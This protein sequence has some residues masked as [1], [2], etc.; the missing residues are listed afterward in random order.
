MKQEKKEKET[1]QIPEL[2][3]QQ[4]PAGEPTPE[5]PAKDWEK[6][7]LTNRAQKEH[8]KS[9][10]QKLEKELEILK[11]QLEDKNSNLSDNDLIKIN[12]DYDLMDEKEKAEFREKVETKKRLLALEAKEKMRQDYSSLPEN[13]KKKVE[14]R[15]GFEIFRDFACLP[16]NVGQKNVLNLARA[17]VFDEEEEEVP[18]EI[19]LE[20]RPGLEQPSSEPANVPF[21]DKMEM[22]AQQVR[23]LRVRNPKKYTELIK[24]K[25]LV[26]RD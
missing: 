14:E 7:A 17:F 25:K 15:G 3:P 22:T 26:I 5:N 12:P 1:P 2:E 4:N 6:E 11:G 13:I 16:E 20:D 23:E 10:S 8:F 21:S 19:S 18:P 9:K 24:S